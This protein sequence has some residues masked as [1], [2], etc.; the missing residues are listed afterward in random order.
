MRRTPSIVALTLAL[1]VVGV[2]AALITLELRSATPD[3]SPR[4]AIE[5]A[6]AERAQARADRYTAQDRS[7]EQAYDAAM[8]RDRIAWRSEPSDPPTTDVT[9]VNATPG[10]DLAESASE[11]ATAVAAES[12]MRTQCYAFASTEAYEF[13]NI[14]EGVSAARPTAIVNLCWAAL[15]KVAGPGGRPRMS[16]LRSAPA[17]WDAQQCPPSWPGTQEVDA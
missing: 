1:L 2:L 9:I 11:C 12:G 6:T 13:K 14:T 7:Y 8:V 17:L 15:A 5:A 10:A 4:A 16:D 3:T